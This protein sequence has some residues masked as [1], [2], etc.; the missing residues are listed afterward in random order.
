[1]ADILDGAQARNFTITSFTDGNPPVGVNL[2]KL[3]WHFVHVNAP[4]HD[5]CPLSIVNYA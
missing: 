5:V 4:V 3:P 2:T 1:M